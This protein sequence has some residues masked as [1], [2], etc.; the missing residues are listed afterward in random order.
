MTGNPVYD[1]IRA[2]SYWSGAR[3]E[4]GDELA[5]VLSLGESKSVNE[6]YDAW[7]TGL[8]LQAIEGRAFRHGLDLGT[9]VGRVAIRIAGR[10][11]RIVGA[12]LASGML[13]RARRNAG[14]AGIQNLDPVR[15]RSDRLPFRDASF[16]LVVCLGLLEHLP[17]PVRSATLRECAR[18]LSTGGFLA[19]ALNNARSAF[20]RDPSDNPHRD[21]LQQESGYYC[22]I[23]GEEA[24]LD[25]AKDQFEDCVVGSNLF[26]SL[27]RHAARGLRDSDRGSQGLRPFFLRAAA[28]D[29]ALR[30]LGPLAAAA[31]DHH[32]HLLVRR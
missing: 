28:W 19:L 9:G 7:E 4:R 25:E 15:L 20:L 1:P 8:L 18:V 26:Y 32:L 13:E 30:P 14:R 10:L 22:A 6:A 24:L 27:H 16:D 17:P 11:T 23:V 29:V 5:A 3:H 31:A 2:A 12:D 21:A